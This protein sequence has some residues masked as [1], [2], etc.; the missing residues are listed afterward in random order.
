MI[1]FVQALISSSLQHEHTNKHEKIIAKSKIRRKWKTENTSGK[2]LQLN[3]IRLT[4]EF[5]S[6]LSLMKQTKH[7]ITKHLS[8]P[9]HN[10]GDLA[11]LIISKTF[12]SYSLI[13]VHI[14]TV[15]LENN[16][17]FVPLFI[18]LTLDLT[19]R[20]TRYNHFKS[21]INRWNP[22]SVSKDWLVSD[23]GIFH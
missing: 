19:N 9:I 11:Y 10:C 17:N 15:I 4:F 13:F 2:G 16:H 1:S 3:D 14:D 7:T 12:N 20:S 8:R 23:S 5:S 21:T 6:C 18:I 22:S